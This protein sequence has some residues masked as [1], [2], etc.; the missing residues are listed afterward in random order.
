MYYAIIGD[1]VSSKSLGERTNIQQNLEEVL[2]SL[3]KEYNNEIKK[4]LSITLG[5][6]FQGL[7]L[8][9]CN[10]LEIIHKIELEMFPVRFRFGIGIGEI[11]FDHGNINSPYRSDGEVWWNAREAIDEVKKLNSTNKQK[12]FS[13]VYIKSNNKSLNNRLNTIL[14]LC[15]AIKVKWT[16]KQLDLIKYT[17]KNYGLTDKFVI[18]KVS[19]HFEQSSSTIYGKYSSSRYINYVNAMSIITNDIQREV[20]NH[21]I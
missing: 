3:N 4:K 21:D 19:E 12:Y 16:V 5:D 2:N 1:I 13:N 8:K 10:L 14:D 7:F 6:E 17:I 11:E 18:N 20:E 9:S 15:Y